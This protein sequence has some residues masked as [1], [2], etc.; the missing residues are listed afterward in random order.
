[1]ISHIP[2]HKP[3]LHIFLKY[4]YKVV[5][6]NSLL[7]YFVHIVFNVYAVMIIY[8]ENR[9][10]FCSQAYNFYSFVVLFNFCKSIQLFI[11]IQIQTI[12]ILKTVVGNIQYSW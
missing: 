6:I 8:V 5:E 2:T 12:I 4:I 7:N 9:Y 11:N 10:Y 3:S 1:M